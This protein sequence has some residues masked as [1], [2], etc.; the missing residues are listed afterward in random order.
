MAI[1]GINEDD[2]DRLG[3]FP[4][5]TKTRSRA[6]A[7][8]KTSF[9]AGRWTRRSQKCKLQKKLHFCV[10]R[11][12]SSWLSGCDRNERAICEA[13]PGQMSGLNLLSA[14]DYSTWVGCD[15]SSQRVTVGFARITCS[16]AS[17]KFSCSSKICESLLKNP[18]PFKDCMMP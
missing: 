14:V 3:Q 10:Q 15:P 12:A 11:P 8:P 9:G 5:Q 7:L 17:P 18:I 16:F 6:A 4:S 1:D 13:S 2:Q